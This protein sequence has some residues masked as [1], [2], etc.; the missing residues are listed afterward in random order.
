MPLCL[1]SSLVSC[2]SAADPPGGPPD[3]EPP[4]IVRV[5]PESGAVLTEPPR[6]VEVAFNE[7]ISERIPG[8]RQDISSAVILSP[9]R[10]ET[11][12]AWRR[13]RLEIWPQEGFER[14]RV[15]HLQLLPVI[16]DL[17]DNRLARGRVVVF[18]TGPQL[19]EATLSGTLV[20]WIG[21]RAAALALVEAVL[22]P[23]SL[24]YRTI[25]DSS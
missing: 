5:A 13:N 21:A 19:P 16:R 6:S 25:T 8:P 1:C 2:A 17:R 23:D 18:S 22:L 24:P 4:L 14:G 11:R 10:G 12:V 9:V 15:Y 7:V 20:D 3:P